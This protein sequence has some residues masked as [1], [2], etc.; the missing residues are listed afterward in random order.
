[1]AKALR[2]AADVV[3]SAS[4]RMV[5]ALKDV[6]IQV[7]KFV[8]WMTV[9]AV[10]AVK[11]FAIAVATQAYKALKAFATFIV[12]TLIPRLYAMGVAMF[13][14]L[15]PWGL[16]AAA[17]VI[18][19]GV[20]VLLLRHFHVLRPVIDA[21]GDAFKFLFN[22]IKDHWKKIVNFIMWPFDQ[23]IRLIKL[24]FVHIYNAFKSAVN[25][26]K[27][28]WKGLAQVLIAIF[29]PGGIIIAAI[30]KWHDKILDIA[31]KV[32][33]GIGHFFKRLPHLV[34]EALKDLPGAIVGLFKNVG[35]KIAKEIFDFIPPKLRGPL[36]KALHLGKDAFDIVT[37]PVGDVKGLYNQVFEKG[38]VVAG[39]D[40]K[41][42][43]VLAHA[44]EWVLNKKQQMKA[45]MHLDM[46]IQNL[47]HFLFGDPQKK[48]RK[49]R[50]DAADMHHHRGDIHA[51]GGRVKGANGQPVRII[52]HAGEW[53]L[54]KAE[55]S[56]LAR[57][58]RE[59]IAKVATFLFGEPKTKKKDSAPPHSPGTST[60]GANTTHKKKRQRK[61]GK[62][63]PYNLVGETDDNGNIVYFVEDAEEQFLELAKIDALHMLRTNGK[64]IPRWIEKYGYHLKRFKNA[65]AMA[66]GYAEGGIVGMNTPTYDMGGV[67]NSPQSSYDTSAISNIGGNTQHKKI[68]QNF[69]VHTQGETDWNYVMRLAAMHAQGSF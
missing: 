55:Q 20:I 36:A 42:V 37:D 59:S 28:H 60:H 69:K 35:K 10:N 47:K 12:D 44:G 57:R 19:I 32:V 8:Y 21:I 45:A 64:F 9:S 41:A 2:K 40:G 68:E 16:I 51:S 48:R 63:F 4:R 24:F 27:D 61:G 26:I 17:V 3:F 6:V 13:A 22:W 1:L 14:A 15:G 52:A 43:P 25:W 65:A 53:I 11:K 23:A 56:K 7:G 49:Q 67:V 31:K 34:L 50:Q 18:L 5:T 66:K 29:L 39:K 58:F 62:F 38:G 30:W 33:F 54:D 46:P